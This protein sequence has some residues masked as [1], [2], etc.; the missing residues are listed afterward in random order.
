[1]TVMQYEKVKNYYIFVKNNQNP[2]LKNEL[3]FKDN[4]QKI[5]FL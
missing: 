3:F 4:L 2:T 5:Y 1:M